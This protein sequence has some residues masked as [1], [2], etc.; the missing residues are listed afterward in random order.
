VDKSL[1]ASLAGSFRDKPENIA[2]AALDH[3][4]RRSQVARD[5][6]TDQA[7]SGVSGYEPVTLFRTQSQEELTRPDLAGF[8]KEG[9]ETVLIEAKFW[10]GLTDQQ[11]NGYLERLKRTNSS[12]LCF[13]VPEAR[14]SALWHE[15]IGRASTG[16]K[17][18]NQGS[19]SFRCSV[20]NERYMSMIT[21][22]GMLNSMLGATNATGQLK[23]A[24][25]IEQLIGL[26][27]QLE[28]EGFVP[29]RTE[30]LGPSVPR[31]INQLTLV[32][33]QVVD[34]GVVQ[35]KYSTKGYRPA[36]ARERF[37]RY[38]RSGD[39]GLELSLH[40]PHWVEHGTSPIWLQFMGGT[41]GAE[42]I[43]FKKYRDR[44]VQY[45]SELARSLFL[46]DDGSPRFAIHL[47]QGA[48]LDKV[49]DSMIE[50]IDS[51]VALLTPE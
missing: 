35:K 22:Q 45:E 29:L 32:V 41:S 5:V 16:F 15:V 44:F 30:D 14:R 9:N 31:L 38:F 6:L 25:D 36:S 4:L 43:R 1:L 12:V 21:W 28:R 20:G 10:A 27:E 49:V 7:Y 24:N 37:T 46:S 42:Y 39:I 2:I 18:E 47:P 19:N 8:D 3:V 51:I 11:P 23:T 48:D 40:Y 26:C 33:D 13:I 17:V 34:S 50:Q